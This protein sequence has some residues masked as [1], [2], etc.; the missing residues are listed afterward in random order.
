MALDIGK[1][2]SI[3]EKSRQAFGI[4]G[5]SV[6]IV[7]GDDTYIRGY[8][9]KE[10]GK[11]DPVTPDTL[12]AV[13]SVT[14]AFTTTAIAMLI[15]E[16]KISWDDHPRR[17]VPE[18]RLSDPLA[19]A[20]V[21]LRDLV[22]HR[23]GLARHD[24]L[25]YNSAWTAQEL[26]ER[27]PYLP[28]TYSF[29]STYQYNNLMYLV[30]GLAA[31]SA[32]GTTWDDFVR[33]RLFNPLGMSR[34]I[35]SVTHLAEAGDFC[36]PHEKKEDEIV[37]VPWCNVDNVAP[38]GAINS[39]ARDMIKWVRFQLGDG[40]WNGQQIISHKNLIETH[41]PQMVVPVDETS[42]DL[43]ETTMTSYC[44]GWNLLI[45]R[46]YTLIAHGGSIDG[47]NA[48]V[49]LVPKAGIGVAILSN[50][51]SDWTVYATRNAILDHLLGLPEKNWTEDILAI[52]KAGRQTEIAAEKARADKRVTGTLPSRDLA[53]YIGT[54][55]D[56]AYGAAIISLENGAPRLAWNNH[57]VKLEH[58]HFDTFDG[59]YDPPDWPVKIEALFGLET[60]GSIATLKLSWPSSGMHRTFRRV[61]E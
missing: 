14:K 18:F 57:T 28:L 6:A 21:T 29:R 30:A 11:T 58:F 20:N 36:T 7:S 52:H 35:T 48:G 4:P 39:C 47:F 46:D 9:D 1:I 44:L 40:T 3:V 54:Y 2:D 61:K 50:L 43:A 13:G 42:R 33:T 59:K 10:M 37:T 22:S 34:S 53:D 25:W 38:C 16:G 24:G 31:A 19:D 27:I 17:H 8:G 12:F 56:D 51:C 32:A 15:D 60:D 26:L 41:L 55:T 5:M 23:T 49:S 45:Y